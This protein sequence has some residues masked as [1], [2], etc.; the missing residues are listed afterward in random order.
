MRAAAHG[1]ALMYHRLGASPL[2]PAEA[3]YTLTRVEFE[4]QMSRLR[5]FPVVGLEALERSPSGGVLLTFD[6]GSDTDESV[7]LPVLQQHGYPGVFFISP[8][9]VERPGYLGWSGARRLA[10]SGMHLGT[11]GLDHTLL[12]ELGDEEVGRQLV[13]S[14]DLL[15]EHVGCRVEA[16]SLPGGSGGRRVARLAHEAGYRFVFG[17]QPGLI[18]EVSES[19]S[20]IPRYAIRR[21]VSLGAFEALLERRTLARLR[22]S[23]RHQALAVAR[24]LLGRGRYASLHRL[25]A[26]FRS[27]C[28]GRGTSSSAGTAPE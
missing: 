17:S 2:D 13:E 20:L 5:A 27:G 3:I 8:A 25:L 23:L 26:G 28:A 16:V 21:G 10:E 11:H 7:A 24:G 4:A 22:Q 18:G 9:L 14:K 15:E 6:D 1:L 19:A 12:G